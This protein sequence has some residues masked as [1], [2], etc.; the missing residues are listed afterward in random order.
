MAFVAVAAL[1]APPALGA[2]D[3]L[4]VGTRVAAVNFESPSA[5]F[6]DYVLEEL[7]GHFVNSKKFVVIERSNLE[8]RRNELNFQMS[9]EVDDES[10]VGIGHALGAQVI[11]AGSLTDLGG[12]YRVR[13]NAIDV[14]KGV[15]LVSPAV[16]VRR[17]NTVAFMLPQETPAA[18][19]AAV[20]SRPDPALAVAYFNAGFAH[21][22]AKRYT[23]A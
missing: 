18:L 7:Q 17:D 6:G 4:P 2:A 13:F 23:E 8:L 20:P 16:T 9:G 15:R 11:V 14:E 3:G 19:P 22:E 10:M 1:A 12:N 21:Y 5:L